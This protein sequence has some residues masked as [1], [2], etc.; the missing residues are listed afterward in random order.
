MAEEDENIPIEIMIAP[1]AAAADATPPP[2][3]PPSV[4]SVAAATL[5]AMPDKK[6][7]RIIIPKKRT[8]AATAAGG[9]AVAASIDPQQ[10]IRMMKKEL[11]DGRKRLKP[12]DL[13]NPFS[14]DF[15]KLLLKKELLER[16]ITIHDIGMLAPDSDDERAGAAAALPRSAA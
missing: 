9:V 5:S 11:D 10:R 16:E 3:P 15:N 12:E 4:A 7:P 2:L 8:A 1:A 6:P 14:K 13:N